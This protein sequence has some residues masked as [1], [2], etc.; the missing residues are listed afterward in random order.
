MLPPPLDI[1]CP[2]CKM[3]KEAWLTTHFGTDVGWL[4]LK[5]EGSN[6]AANEILE[7]F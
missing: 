4:S 3:F 7:Q 6:M 1:K 2:L 5:K